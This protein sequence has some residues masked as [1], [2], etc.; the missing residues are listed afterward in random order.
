MVRIGG[1]ADGALRDMVF[2]LRSSFFSAHTS[3]RLTHVPTMTH[4]V[5]NENEPKAWAGIDEGGLSIRTETVFRECEDCDAC[6]R[7]LPADRRERRFCDIVPLRNSLK[8]P[9][10]V[11]SDW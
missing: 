10:F 8:R 2:L 9:L 1:G 3:A 7:G 11:S 4:A 6:C 5:L